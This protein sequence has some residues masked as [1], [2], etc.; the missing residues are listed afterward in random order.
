MLVTD[1]LLMLVLIL[2]ERV[3]DLY[4]Y[5]FYAEKLLLMFIINRNNV[6]IFTNGKILD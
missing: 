4:L 2:F 5:V 3:L 6:A 1:I